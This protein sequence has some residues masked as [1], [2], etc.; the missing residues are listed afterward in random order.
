MKGK[1]IVYFSTPTGE[2]KLEGC[3]DASISIKSIPNGPI[4]MGV[5]WA[6]D[7]AKSV[8]NFTCA[9]QGSWRVSEVEHYLYLL[10]Q[11]FHERTEEYDRTVCSGEIIR[12]SIMPVTPGERSMCNKN[13]LKIR[14]ELVRRAKMEMGIHRDEV[15]RAFGR[16]GR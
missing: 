10:A 13:A 16:Y 7:I 6:Q 11:E 4:W 15:A 1:K 2:K 8:D 5:D 9:Y 14:E 3:I 12:G